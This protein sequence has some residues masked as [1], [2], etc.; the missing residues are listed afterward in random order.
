[1]AERV[2][3]D[4]LLGLMGEG[5]RSQARAMIRAG[6][7]TVDGAAP[8]DPGLVVDPARAAV[9]LDGRALAYRRH[10]HVMLHKPAGVLTAAM[11]AKAGTVMDLLPPLY[12]A[13]GCM[14]V[15]RLDRDTEGLLLLTTDGALA[16]RLL[17]PKSGVEKVYLARVDG[18]LDARDVSAF[19]AGLALS[20]FAA[21]PA[22]L[23]ILESGPAS[24]RALCAVREGKF[25]QVKRMF[26]ARGR[27]VTALKRLS[28][29]PLTLDDALAPGA[30][31]ALTQA[32]TA[33]L[34]AAVGLPPSEEE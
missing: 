2:R 4:R 15:G 32:E 23:T 11:D 9:A 21:L 1:M 16:H 31:R 3:L 33:A 24:A 6:R 22:T 19:A 7:V 17:S 25:H 5:T 28:I 29:G 10:R 26:A 12:R 20:D 27:T 18:P 13:C 34:R 8:R 30:H 14:P